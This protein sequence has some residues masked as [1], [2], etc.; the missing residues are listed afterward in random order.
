VKIK[1]VMVKNVATCGP[2]DNVAEV[3]AKMWDARCGSLPV[4]ND[5]GTVTG[6]ITDR[7]ICIALGTRNVRASELKVKDVAL[8]RVFCCGTDDDVLLALKTMVAQ[9]IRRL[10]VVDDVG[11]LAGILS[12]DDLLLHSGRTAGK[13]GISHDDVVNAA[14]LILMSRTREA[15]HQP[16]ELIAAGSF[17]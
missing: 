6:L 3:A 13:T 10:P 7:D 5:R 4:V 15:V 14:K 2:D 16:G 12:I 11:K 8:P 17:S 9:N 1:N